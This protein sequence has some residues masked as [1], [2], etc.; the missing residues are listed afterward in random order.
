MAALFYKKKPGVINSLTVNIMGIVISLQTF[1]ISKP[2]LETQFIKVLL[3]PLKYQSFQIMSLHQQCIAMGL[4][5]QIYVA[6]N[7]LKR[8]LNVF[9]WSTLMINGYF[10]ITISGA[11]VVY[12]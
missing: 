12:G 11:L 7:G 2:V 6:F 9:D 10:T 5:L 1:F 8:D 4:V 3:F